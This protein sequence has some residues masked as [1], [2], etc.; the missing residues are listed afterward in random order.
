MG[1]F[2]LL[3][4]MARAGIRLHTDGEKIFAGPREALTDELRDAIRA[5]KLA[6]LAALSEQSPNGEKQLSTHGK[7]RGSS[8]KSAPI[9]PDLER[10][11]REMAVWWRYSD[12]ETQYALER[13]AE[14]HVG[15]QKLVEDDE[16]W[17]AEHPDRRPDQTNRIESTTW[18][19]R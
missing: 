4:M 7:G 5:N 11:I 15:W 10:R 13:A 6:L 16:R 19:H 1:A 14:D 8:I 18:A 12:E 2:D 9:T 3:G 17:R